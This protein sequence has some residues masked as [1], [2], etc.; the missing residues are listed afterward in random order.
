MKQ[1]VRLITVS[2]I[3]IVTLV[4]NAWAMQEFTLII[5]NHKF[6]PELIT[7]P[8]DTKVRL[9]VKNQDTTPEEFDSAELHREKIIQGH[10]QGIV[11]IGPLSPGNYSFMGEFHQAT[12][13]GQIVVK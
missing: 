8:A 3:L 6:S 13:K 2:G 7:I 11:F 10:G 4:G 9:L 5:K 1:I 12:A